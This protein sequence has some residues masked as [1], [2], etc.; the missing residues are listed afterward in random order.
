MKKIISL[1]VISL[2]CMT[3]PGCFSQYYT[4]RSDEYY[5][6]IV[7]EQPVLINY[8]DNPVVI[9]NNPTT[10][11]E[12]TEKLRKNPSSVIKE[13]TNNNSDKQSKLRNLNSGS[14][15]SYSDRNSGS[16]ESV[17][18]NNTQARNTNGSRSNSEIQNSGNSDSSDND[19]RKSGKSVSGQSRR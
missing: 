10:G 7:I 4:E 17:N 19:S 2:F 5:E 14:Q 13:R 1:L 12:S 6:Y 18:N 9:I 11:T 16:T 8:P 15:Q 3:F